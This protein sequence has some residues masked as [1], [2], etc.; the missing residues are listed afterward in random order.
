MEADRRRAA[1]RRMSLGVF[2]KT[3]DEWEVGD[4]DLLALGDK[5]ASLRPSCVSRDK[6][7]GRQRCGRAAEAT[8]S[9]LVC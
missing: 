2:P 6:A 8:T 3:V 5:A 1:T 7:C 4:K 9:T